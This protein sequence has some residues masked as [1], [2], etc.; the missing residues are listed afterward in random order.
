MNFC[1]EKPKEIFYF[2]FNFLEIIC[3]KGGFIGMYFDLTIRD[4]FKSGFRIVP[5]PL[6]GIK[7]RD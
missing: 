1:E 5:S 7:V 4:L 6:L 2:Y 3:I